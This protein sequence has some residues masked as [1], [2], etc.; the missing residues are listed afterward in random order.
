MEDN[1]ARSNPF[2]SDKN[3]LAQL[4]G[5]HR[6]LLH[7]AATSPRQP[8]PAPPKASRVLETVTLVLKRAGGPMRAREIHA[9]AQ[10]LDR[11]TL[12]WTSVKSTLA[13]GATGPS[14]LFQRIRRGVYQLERL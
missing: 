10:L 4:G 8:R 1:G 13:R 9:E 11:N 14:P 3:Q 2:T 5:L 7:K 12:L 6:Q